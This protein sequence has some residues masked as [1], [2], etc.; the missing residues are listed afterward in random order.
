MFIFK[1]IITDKFILMSIYISLIYNNTK[2]L[3]YIINSIKCFI[4]YIPE[5]PLLLYYKE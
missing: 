1:I 2:I 4:Q 5:G 3:A